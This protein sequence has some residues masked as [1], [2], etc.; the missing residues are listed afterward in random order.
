MEVSLSPNGLI[1]LVGL[2]QRGLLKLGNLN[3]VGYVIIGPVSYTVAKT[4]G[5]SVVQQ[6]KRYL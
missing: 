4:P 1:F 2:T 3:G 5:F 6:T